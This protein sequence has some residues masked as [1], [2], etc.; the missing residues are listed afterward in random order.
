MI[1]TI[2]SIGS[3]EFCVDPN[4][5][6]FVDT[7]TILPSPAFAVTN[8]IVDTVCEG[9]ILSIFT[10]VQDP[11][12]LPKVKYEWLLYDTYD[13]TTSF[14]EQPLANYV[15]RSKYQF[16]N[17][18]V[19]YYIN[20]FIRQGARL[21]YTNSGCSTVRNLKHSVV[22]PRPE[23]LLKNDNQL[24]NSNAGMLPIQVN[25]NLDKVQYSL[26]YMSHNLTGSLLDDHSFPLSGA[27]VN[28]TTNAQKLGIIVKS[29]LYGCVGQVDTAFVEVRNG[30]EDNY[31]FTSSDEMVTQFKSSA[32]K[33]ADDL[34]A[35]FQYLLSPNPASSELTFS[36][37]AQSSSSASVGIYS[38][39]GQQ[40][41]DFTFQTQKGLNAF[42]CSLDRL[43][44]G[45]Y[46]LLFKSAE[47]VKTE[48]FEKL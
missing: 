7:I 24:I 35:D 41:M 40:I 32:R 39:S 17:S 44:A 5:K 31:D 4:G 29:S 20:D 28:N 16:S 34:G 25:T 47:N 15:V 36:F 42:H 30:I 14:M 13:Y 46:I 38:I 8:V 10:P 21:T 6:E 48:R 3:R 22:I 43:P 9:S 11:T 2:K 26:S 27:L 33:V 19:F 18:S 37:S 23:F 45:S 1:F 12:N